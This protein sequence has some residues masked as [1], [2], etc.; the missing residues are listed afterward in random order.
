MAH[1]RKSEEIFT[2]FSRCNESRIFVPQ[3]DSLF[4]A[5]APKTSM[6]CC[7]GMGTLACTQKSTGELDSDFRVADRGMAGLIPRP[8]NLPFSKLG[9]ALPHRTPRSA[10]RA[11]VILACVSRKPCSPTGRQ[12][13][14]AVLSYRASAASWQSQTYGRRRTHH[15]SK[16]QREREHKRVSESTAVSQPSSRQIAYARP[17]TNKHMSLNLGL[18]TGHPKPM[19]DGSLCARSRRELSP[20]APGL[21]TSRQGQVQKEKLVSVT[22]PMAWPPQ[23]LVLDSKLCATRP[24]AGKHWTREQCKRQRG[25]AL[26][27]FPGCR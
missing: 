16:A 10:L 7:G 22:G 9:G 19:E 21:S 25:Q 27:F 8:K 18:P 24:A 1:S 11:A 6:C 4:S 14:A 15:A 3:R 13:R 2:N 26:S 17:E 12:G 20:T 5:W 23:G